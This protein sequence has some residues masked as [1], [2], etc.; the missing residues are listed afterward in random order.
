MEQIGFLGQI[1]LATNTSIFDARNKIREIAALLE[2]NLITSTQLASEISELCR[3]VRL[4][5]TEPLLETWITPKET[6]S[7]SLKCAVS[8]IGSTPT[9]D[10]LNMVTLGQ[11]ASNLVIENHR[12]TVQVNYE[13]NRTHY[14]PALFSQLSDVMPLLACLA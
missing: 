14:N 6:N 7:I 10:P 3:W 9:L 12:F 8:A 13:F 4:A 1:N 11:V 2:L 5:G